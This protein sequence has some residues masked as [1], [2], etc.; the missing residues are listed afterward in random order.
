[1]YLKKLRIKNYRKFGE[2]GNELEFVSSDTSL[3]QI[4][5]TSTLIVGKN[6]TGKTT[7]TK[8]ISKVLEDGRNLKGTDFNFTYLKNILDHNKTSS[9]NTY[10]LPQIEFDL[11][12]VMSSEDDLL[13]NVKEFINS[14][15]VDDDQIEIKIF[16]SFEIKESEEFRE[17]LKTII[18][19][20]ITTKIQSFQKLNNP[21]AITFREVGDRVINFTKTNERKLFRK[22]VELIDKTEFKLIC[23]NLHGKVVDGNSFRLSTLIDVKQISAN[24][25]LHDKNLSLIFNKI[26]KN[27]YQSDSGGRN[28]EELLEEIERVNNQI[29]TRVAADHGQ[30]VNGVLHEVEVKKRLGINLSSSLDFDK[31]TKDLIRYEYTESDFYIPEGQ[32]GLGYT[33]LMNIIGEIIDYVEKFP[34]DSGKSKVN[35]I[36]IE[37]PEA[38]MHP[39]MQESFIKYIN[40]A[41]EYLLRSSGKKINSQLIIT[42][43]SSHILNSKIHVSNTFNNIN[44]ITL[45]NNS[46]EVIVLGDSKIQDD[47]DYTLKEN[48]TGDELAQRKVDDLKFLK[49]HIKFKVSD[50]FFA[51]GVIFVE[52]VT[53]ETLLSYYISKNKDLN[54]HYISIININGAH[55]LVYLSL[56][57]ALKIPSLIITDL[58]IVRTDEESYETI[59]EGPDA[60][61]VE[62]YVQISNL[63][64]RV[65]TNA[66]INKLYNGEFSAFREQENIFCVFQKDII[67]GFHATSFEE[68]LILSNYSNAV[69]NKVLKKVKPRIYQSIVGSTPN[70]E[71]VRVN[72][73]KF[74][75]K[76]AKDKSEFSNELLYELLT[77]P[78]EDAPVL[79][80]YISNGLK[81]LENKMNVNIQGGR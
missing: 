38:F 52:G 80:D 23:K 72:S 4:A 7:V 51:D 43:H 46:A 12:V 65:S 69:L 6:N 20:C 9:P 48:E 55:G 27:K 32:F 56:L 45:N 66:T 71:N 70:L 34:L 21:P 30:A 44:Y 58:D 15:E 31:L 74:Q 75:A 59:G 22:F 29:T 67:N 76:L 63:E 40:N 60:K 54:K 1:M 35:L 10:Q 79:P 18:E 19:K 62:R 42:T 36:C 73:F 78:E 14:G 57:K 3:S 49:N 39:Q 37:E 28:L 16:L 53:E 11:S 50:L 13:N 25:N 41:V 47:S 68:A 81:W 24:S 26:I 2:T 17:K 5:G 64:G 33:N 61:E 77:V 8:A